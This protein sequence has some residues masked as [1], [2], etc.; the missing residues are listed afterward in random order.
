MVNTSFSEVPDNYHNTVYEHKRK[1]NCWKNCDVIN[2]TNK[3]DKSHHTESSKPVFKRPT[4]PPKKDKIVF[5]LKISQ[6]R[7][8]DLKNLP[9]KKQ[10]KEIR[11]NGLNESRLAEE[12]YQ[13]ETCE[14]VRNTARSQIST[15]NVSLLELINQFLYDKPVV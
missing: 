6:K 4:L 3:S 8:N 11:N 9:N 7:F 14:H 2:K 13:N 10:E 1:T 12:S 15:K 5:N